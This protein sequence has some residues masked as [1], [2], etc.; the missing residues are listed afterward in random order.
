MASS[1]AT[2]FMPFHFAKLP[3]LVCIRLM[4]YSHAFSTEWVDCA[5][6]TGIRTLTEIYACL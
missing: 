1:L 4:I 5:L 6:F 2:T 3:L